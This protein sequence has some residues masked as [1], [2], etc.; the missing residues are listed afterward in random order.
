M[1]LWTRDLG[2]PT[3]VVKSGGALDSH[4]QSLTLAA[5][6]FT[7]RGKSNGKNVFAGS[8]GSNW[9]D[10]PVL[11]RILVL[12]HSRITPLAVCCLFKLGAVLFRF[13]LR[14]DYFFSFL[15]PAAA[16]N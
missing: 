7:E 14:L 5:F 10:Q 16:C 2:M 3:V 8:H 1:R 9:L 15:L 4:W 11:R 12:T 13:N 6:P